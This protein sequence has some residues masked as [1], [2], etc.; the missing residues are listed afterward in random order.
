MG[1][2]T[3]LWSSL[4]YNPYQATQHKHIFCLCKALH[5]KKITE[6]T[7]QFLLVQNSSVYMWLFWSFWAVCL[8][9]YNLQAKLFNQKTLVTSY[10]GY[11]RALNHDNLHVLG[12]QW[13]LRWQRTISTTLGGSGADYL[14]FRR[15]VVHVYLKLQNL[16]KLP[17]SSFFFLPL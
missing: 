6:N 11:R 7:F 14:H 16:A 10:V 8:F 13:Q 1:G 4:L 5:I 2:M 12:L 15:R 17:V 9:G 3:N